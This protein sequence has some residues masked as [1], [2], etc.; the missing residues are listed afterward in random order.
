MDLRPKG[1]REGGECM[2]GCAWV[3]MADTYPVTCSLLFFIKGVPRSE[4]TFS[5]F[6]F[7]FPHCHFTVSYKLKSDR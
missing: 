7:L 2:H 6:S 4:E 3:E 5:L 1:R